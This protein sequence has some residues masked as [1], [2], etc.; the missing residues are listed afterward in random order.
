MTRTAA[1]R[2]PLLALLALVLWSCPLWQTT[3]HADG[4][5]GSSGEIVVYTDLRAI[6]KYGNVMLVRDEALV[7]P[8]DLED[9]G[10]AYGDIVEV[11]F[12][13]Q[14]MDVPVVR[15]YGE[16]E[17]G[18]ALIRLKDEATELG[19][20]M[21]DFASAYLADK[22]DGEDGAVAWTYKEG[23]DGPVAI[24]IV[25]V[26]KGGYAIGD[27]LSYTDER[28][29]YPELSDAEF[30]NF[31]VVATT[32]M[33]ADTL[34]RT[35]SPINP[36][37]GRS[38]YAD[39]AL[40]EAG[41]RTVVNLADNS[42]VAQAYEGFDASYYATT[43]YVTLDMG[44]SFATDDFRGRLAEGLRFLARSEG[45]YAIHCN[46]GKD[47]AG[48]VAA[49]LECLMGA[50]YDEV[51]A[52][53]M[54]SYANYYGI[55]PD[56]PRYDEIADE[57]IGTTLRAMFGTDD[58]AGA[59]LSVEAQE[60]VAEIGLSEAEIES[61]R[62]HLGAA[63]QMSASTPAYVYVAAAGGVVVLVGG[64]YLYRRRKAA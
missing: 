40:K 59:D 9:A 5:S 58:L 33:A 4:G 31:R 14:T 29:D 13:D 18:D 2:L 21:G 53:Y 16:V 42:A 11:R 52:D 61:L 39:A 3:A 54:T 35:S 46:E 30:A 22:S 26:E 36:K 56:D 64:I 63:Q 41:V 50:T 49:L 60:Y 23:I 17:V 37:H 57:N 38:A 7:L 43:N 28:A 25:L 47:R 12:L 55:G 62:A 34:Y 10:I 19:L 51:R 24:D 45:P 32:G 20:N 1:R 6:T 27:G 48:V 15:E 44:T 8:Q